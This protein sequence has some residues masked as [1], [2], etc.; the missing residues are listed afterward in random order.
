MVPAVGS[1][2]MRTQDSQLVLIGFV[3]KHR[4]RGDKVPKRVRL[5]TQKQNA[6]YSLTDSGRDA[7]YAEIPQHQADEHAPQQFIL[8]ILLEAQPG[9]AGKCG[10]IYFIFMRLTEFFAHCDSAGYAVY[11]RTAV[12]LPH[13]LD[14]LVSSHGYLHEDC[15]TTQHAARHYQMPSWYHDESTGESSAPPRYKK[16]K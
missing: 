3:L 11:K 12:N 16:R 9:R 1:V 8:Q 5:A 13:L 4:R 7:A 14:V 10:S 15:V 2:E 6:V